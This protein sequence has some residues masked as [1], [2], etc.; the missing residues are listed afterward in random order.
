MGVCHPPLIIYCTIYFLKQK[1]KRFLLL[2]FCLMMRIHFNIGSQSLSCQWPI[3][4]DFPVYWVNLEDSW[5]RRE[6]F[7]NYLK[8]INLS[9]NSK[10]VNAIN[11]K[12]KSSYHYNQYIIS[13]TDP[14]EE[15]DYAVIGSHLSALRTAVANQKRFKHPY[16]IISEDDN[17][18]VYCVD[19]AQ[20]IASAP[21]DFTVLQISTSNFESITNL[22]RNYV[23]NN[24][25]TIWE[26][27]DYNKHWSTQA[28]IVN[29]RKIRKFLRTAVEPERRNSSTF[30]F[31]L[32]PPQ[33]LLSLCNTKKGLDWDSYDP[34]RMSPPSKMKF[35]QWRND[36][37]YVSFRFY[38]ET[39]LYESMYPA[40][41]SRL[42]LMVGSPQSRSSTLHP[43]HVEKFHGE[44][45]RKIVSIRE[46]I[47]S[48]SSLKLP[49]FLL[50]FTEEKY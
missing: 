40:Y 19:F 43:D 12:K 8:S 6:E 4:N 35:D 32:Y 50:G 27:R 39:Y 25:E 14:N 31:S 16:A 1:M 11:C 49:P 23:K 42:S 2:F 26:R 18:F 21:P 17:R 36:K 47:R 33:P 34:R 3:S 29:T 28:Y 48:N 24:S 7:S 22:W 10:R 5:E 13:A 20:L 44:S 45:F 46:E 37:C 38:V 9:Q 41:I 15:C 30:E